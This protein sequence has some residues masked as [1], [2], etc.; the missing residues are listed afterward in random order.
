ME[1]WKEEGTAGWKGAGILPSGISPSL[2]PGLSS[3]GLLQ[4]AE[5]AA[6]PVDSSASWPWFP[7]ARAVSGMVRP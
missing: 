4:L 1:R 3:Q 6:L 7:F 2:G 5:K